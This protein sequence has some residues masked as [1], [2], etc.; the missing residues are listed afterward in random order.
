MKVYSDKKRYKMGDTILIFFEKISGIRRSMLRDV[1]GVLK[2]VIVIKTGSGKEKII[3][4][5]LYDE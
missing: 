4:E 3:E 1:K 5:V 2:R